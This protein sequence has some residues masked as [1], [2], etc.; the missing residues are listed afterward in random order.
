V[1]FRVCAAPAAV[2]QARHCVTA[3]GDLPDRALLDAQ[4]VVSELVTNSILHAGLDADDVIDVALRRDD[5]RILVEVDDRDGLYGEAG[6]HP[7][8]VRTGGMGLKLLD[9]ICDHWHAE[10]GRVVASV[11]IL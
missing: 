4:V 3:L 11:P 8:P 9:A 1:R 7:A 2:A 6:N 5:E 10:A